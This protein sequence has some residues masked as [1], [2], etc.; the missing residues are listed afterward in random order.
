MEQN[1]KKCIDLIMKK[2]NVKNVSELSYIFCK[3]SIYIKVTNKYEKSFIL[4]D[5]YNEKKINKN[6]F[7]LY[8]F[9]I[10]ELT[11]HYNIAKKIQKFYD[12]KNDDFCESL[13]N[14][15]KKSKARD[16]YIYYKKND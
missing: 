10:C 4:D 3:E 5:D 15:L 14:F 8:K 13:C 12:F 7:F 6:Y 1:V 9:R 16:L 2:L 11:E